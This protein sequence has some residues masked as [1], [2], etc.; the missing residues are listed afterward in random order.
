LIHTLIENDLVDEYLLHVYPIVLGNGKK[1]FPEGG[2]VNLSLVEAKPL[3]SG[4]V[5]MHYVRG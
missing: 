5:Y 4:V 1:L 2:R 3:P